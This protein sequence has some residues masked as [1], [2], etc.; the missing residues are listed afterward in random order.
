MRRLSM[1][2]GRR[3]PRCLGER[4][5]C[6]AAR[7]TRIATARHRPLYG[8]PITLEQAKAAIAAATE[9]SKKNG[10]TMFLLSST[11]AVI[12]LHLKKPISLAMPLST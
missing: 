2:A 12:L 3:A 1:L 4:R 9:E 6:T 7:C 10:G 5:S 8:A 11:V